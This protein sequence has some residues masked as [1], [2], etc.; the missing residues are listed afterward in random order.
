VKSLLLFPHSLSTIQVASGVAKKTPADKQLQRD[1]KAIIKKSMVLIAFMK[2]FH[3][4]NSPNPFRTP[5]NGLPLFCRETALSAV[6][7]T[8]LRL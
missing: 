7:P 3:A 2:E 6:H 1:A 8:Q 5:R 4:D